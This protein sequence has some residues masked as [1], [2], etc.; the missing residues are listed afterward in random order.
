MKRNDSRLFADTRSVENIIVRTSWPCVVPKPVRSTTPRQPPSGVLP[1]YQWQDQPNEVYT[2]ATRRRTPWSS[3]E[4]LR[5]G[6]EDSIPVLTVHVKLLVPF[7]QLDR[8]LEQRCG[9]A[10]EHGFIDNARALDEED[11]GRDRG[12]VLLTDCNHDVRRR[13]SRY[14]IGN[15]TYRWRQRRREAARRSERR[16]TAHYADIG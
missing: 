3:L 6:E 13:E 15:V 11:I 7:Q 2:Y 5:A 4:Y 14:M 9:L 10:G 12:F 16:S 1:A 8:F